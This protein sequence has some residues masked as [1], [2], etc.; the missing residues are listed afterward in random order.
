M[1]FCTRPSFQRHHG[2]FTLLELLVASVVLVLILVVLFSII[3]HTSE[4]WRRSRGQI[5]AFQSARNAYELLTR[6]LSQATLNTYWRYDNA[7]NPARYLRASDLHFA[8]QKAGAGVPGT[9]GTGS[10]VFFQAPIGSVSTNSLQGLNTL[11]NGMGYYIEFSG[12][13]PFRPSILSGEQKYRYRLMQ[14]R[15]PSEKL[16]VYTA[17]NAGDYTW[18]TSQTNYGYPVCDNIILLVT[19]PRLPVQENPAGDDLSTNFT[20]NSRLN[21]TNVNQPRTASQLP[22]IVE[23]LM[24]AIDETSAN[25]LKD[26]SSEPAAIKSALSGKFIEA[27]QTAFEA[28]LKQLESALIGAKVNYQVFR[29][30]IPIRES[31][32]SE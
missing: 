2:A 26:A 32:W 30:S 4:V 31:K 7:T 25:R 16:S 3:S 28:D 27:R 14:M 18:F 15:I 29:S 12:D 19:W 17:T 22:P 9:P 6:N 20:Y 8:I 1:D 24:V 13:G 21:A 10:G 5:E 11:L 23:V